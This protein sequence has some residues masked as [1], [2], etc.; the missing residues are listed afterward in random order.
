MAGGGGLPSGQPGSDAMQKI[1]APPPPAAAVAEK[2]E[3]AE[4]EAEA[5]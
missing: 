1:F 4:A 3:L 5:A 2:S